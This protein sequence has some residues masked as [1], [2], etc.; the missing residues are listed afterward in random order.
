MANTEKK[1]KKETA[2]EKTAKKATAAKKPAAKKAAEEVKTAAAPKKAVTAKKT[3]AAGKTTAKKTTTAK[4]AVTA[5][6]TATA[7]KTSA[8]KASTKKTAVKKAVNTKTAPHFGELDE[9]LFGTATHHEIVKKMGAHPD[10]KDGQSGVWVTVWAPNA[11]A[12][13]VVGDFNGWDGKNDV[14]E[15]V[16]DMGVYEKFVPGA[17]VGDYYKY[18]IFTADERILMK[19]DPYAFW[20]EKRP[21][22]ASRIA[23]IDHYKWHDATWMKK[24]KEFDPKKSALAIYEVHPGSWM[25]HPASDENPEG[26]YTYRQ[27]ADRAVEYIK[28]MGYTHVELMGMAEHPLDASWGYQVTGYYAPTSR[29]GTPEDFQYMIDTFHKNGIGVI[30]D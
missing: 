7:K 2:A 3:A 20:A 8:A 23:D 18:K 11:R 21:G 24:R 4:K 17:K 6:K 29:Y 15:K 13:Q 16:S 28:D 30:L 10:K 14:M 22:T 1:T 27:F 25:K 9:H 12:I 5:K 26:F 19:A